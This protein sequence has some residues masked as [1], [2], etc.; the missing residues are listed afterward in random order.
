MAEMHGRKLTDLMIATYERSL[1]DI[2]I[3][4]LKEAL[5][6]TLKNVQ[7]WPTPAHIHKQLE[8]VQLS[9]AKATTQEVWK[10]PED[11]EVEP[12]TSEERAD[13]AKKLR[14]RVQSEN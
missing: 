9:R 7:Y 4:D 11:W 12:D 13:F 1:G 5:R 2:P 8:A 14:E 6:E 10:P 3:D